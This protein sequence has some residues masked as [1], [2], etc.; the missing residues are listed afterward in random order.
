MC[1]LEGMF[2]FVVFVLLCGLGFTLF[3]TRAAYLALNVLVD[4]EVYQQKMLKLCLTCAYPQV[5]GAGAG[6]CPE[7]GVDPLHLPARRWNLYSLLPLLGGVPVLAA[8][9]LLA[10]I[11]P[12]PTQALIGLVLTALPFSMIAL[13]ASCSTAARWPRMLPRAIGPACGAVYLLL[14]LC[15]GVAWL[16]VHPAAG[17]V[18]W[19]VL[20]PAVGPLKIWF[21][22]RRRVGAWATFGIGGFVGADTCYDIE[23]RED[24][25]ANLETRSGQGF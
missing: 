20:A 15:T 19:I 6:V 4:Y 8:I 14:A 18:F 16:M 13:A 11:V 24:A 22:V 21:N 7:C 17:L 23:M 10:G 2:C 9:Y 25:P 1:A 5:H 12:T 3:V